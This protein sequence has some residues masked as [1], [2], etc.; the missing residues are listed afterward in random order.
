MRRGEVETEFQDLMIPDQNKTTITRSN[1]NNFIHSLISDSES[2][3][4]KQREKMRHEKSRGGDR[5][6]GLDDPRSKQNNDHNINNL[7]HSLISDL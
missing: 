5:V 2:I 3:C 7:I 1:I 6:P 4:F